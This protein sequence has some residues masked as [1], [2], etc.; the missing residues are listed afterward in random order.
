MSDDSRSRLTESSEFGGPAAPGDGRMRLASLIRRG[1]RTRLSQRPPWGV[2][3]FQIRLEVRM[4]L[5]RGMHSYHRLL[6]LPIRERLRAAR[7]AMKNT[8]GST[9][10]CF[11]NSWNLLLQYYFLVKLRR[12]RQLIRG[13]VSHAREIGGEGNRENEI[14]DLPR[15]E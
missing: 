2:S 6:L 4:V 15:K 12:E 5:T 8:S 7:Y 3:V 13:D 14:E 1:R 10:K 11:P 9:I